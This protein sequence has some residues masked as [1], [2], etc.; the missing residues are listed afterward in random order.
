MDGPLP[1]TDNP[2][3]NGLYPAGTE[4]ALNFAPQKGR[5]LVADEPVEDPASLLGIVLGAVEFS[6]CGNGLSD[7][8]SGKFVKKNPVELAPFFLE[9]L[10][11]MPGNRFTFPVRVGCQVDFHGI[12]GSFF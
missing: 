3:G 10:G 1:F 4:S 7:G 6:R 2:N 11:R 5:Y 12:G 8:V 9:N